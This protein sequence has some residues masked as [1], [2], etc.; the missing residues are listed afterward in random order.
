MRN[1]TRK[2]LYRI[3]TKANKLK[4]SRFTQQ[5]I[6][7]GNKIKISDEEYKF[8]KPDEEAIDA[9]ILTFRFFIVKNEATSFVKL[10]KLTKSPEI[11]DEWKL[12]FIY[13][14]TILNEFLDNHY[15]TYMINGNLETPSNRDVLYTFLYGGLVHANQ[16][17]M[18]DKFEQWQNSPFF[19]FQQLTFISVLQRVLRIILFIADIS[20]REIERF[21]S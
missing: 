5:L 19:D 8:I 16:S 2:I 7:N 15:G 18:I 9:F 4:S 21:V 12:D 3:I 14:K 20:K 10:S 13:A 1:E 11:S 17:V 6:D